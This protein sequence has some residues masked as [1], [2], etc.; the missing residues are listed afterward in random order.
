M[1]KKQLFSLRKKKIG[2]CSVILGMAIIGGAPMVAHADSVDA[3]TNPITELVAT[4][5]GDN[6]STPAEA[7]TVVPTASAPAVESVTSSTATTTDSKQSS[8]VVFLGVDTNSKTSTET[9]KATTEYRLDENLDAGVTK[10]VS[11]AKDGQT[12]TTEKTEVKQTDFDALVD[13]RVKDDTNRY[14]TEKFYHIDNS[15]E[16]PSDRIVIDKI[17]LDLP[18]DTSQFD[19]GNSPKSPRELA[20]VGN[21]VYWNKGKKVVPQEY[22]NYTKDYLPFENT[23]GALGTLDEIYYYNTSMAK[24]FRIA[25]GEYLSD[26]IPLKSNDSDDLKRYYSSEFITDGLYADAKAAY[27][28]VEDAMNRAKQLDEKNGSG[29]WTESNG[30][31]LT[32]QAKF[33]IASQ[34]FDTITQRYNNSRGYYGTK[35]NYAT[36]PSM[37]TEERSEFEATIKKL[38]L[39]IR[40]NILNL[41]VSDEPLRAAEKT[42]SPAGTTTHLSQHIDLLNYRVIDSYKLE[43]ISG[44]EVA[45]ERKG[46]LVPQPKRMISVLLHEL[47]HVIDG[48]S[49]T[50]LTKNKPED[51]DFGTEDNDEKVLVGFSDSEEFKKIYNTYFKDKIVA[52][53]YRDNIEEAFADSLGGYIEYRILG[54]SPEHYIKRPDKDGKEHIITLLE[55]DEFYNS[56]D[57]YDP[58]L[59]AEAETGYYSKLY[60]KLFEDPSVVAMK[61]SKTVTKTDVQNGLVVYGAKPTEKTIITPFKVIYKSDDSKDFGYIAEVGGKNGEKIIRT[62]YVLKDNKP[63]AVEKVLSDIAAV[64]KVV[65]KGTKTKTAITDVIPTAIKYVQDATLDKGVEKA[66]D[67]HVGSRGYTT[68]TTTYKLNPVTGEITSSETKVVTPMV[69]KVVYVGTKVTK[70]DAPKQVEQPAKKS[71]LKPEIKPDQQHRPAVKPAVSTKPQVAVSQKTPKVE[72]AYVVSAKLE[73]VSTNQV[74]TVEATQAVVN[75]RGTTDYQ[76]VLPQTGEADT[77]VYVL[78]GLGMIGLAGVGLVNK[79]RRN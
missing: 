32:N 4:S 77:A 72:K 24:L 59:T 69:E 38:P 2:L 55:G 33:E 16:I 21:N 26:L 5:G 9:V 35:I 56:P 13:P 62:S 43:V 66:D 25:S 34:A 6:T 17:Y 46:V 15:K 1:K 12:T 23:K 50:H 40:Q 57:A 53:Y 79:E 11:E 58:L 64:D 68:V 74:A 65:T 75:R 63:E 73:Q 20:A 47:S 51:S 41:L 19:L 60:A 39:A 48:F 29:L 54:I 22:Y 10:V 37:T 30:S 36:A 78:A 52:T 70:V 49:G 27:M 45:V 61:N 44:K 71:E 14:V 76:A 3:T 18:A 31:G 28:R 8:D 67:K 42:S 7:N